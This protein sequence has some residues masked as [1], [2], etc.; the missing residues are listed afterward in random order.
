MNW[1][2]TLTAYPVVLFTFFI[3]FCAII[4]SF[5]NVIIYRYPIM[6]EREWENDCLEQL[7][8]PLKPKTDRFNICLPHSHCPTC[9]H[10]IPFW[11]N[12]PIISYLLLKG[13]CKFCSAPISFQYFLVEILSP[14]LGTIVVLQYGFTPTGM[15]LLLVTFGLLVLS[16]I[17]FNHH[18]LPDVIT[19]ILLWTGL[20]I[21]TQH[22]L[23][24]SSHAIFGAVTGYLFLWGIAK[25]Y[26]LFRKKEGMG[27]G[28]CKM[29]AMI[30]AFVGPLA[31]PNV[32]LLSTVLALFVSI[33]L[34]TIKKI[35]HSNPIPFGPYIA[36]AGWCVILFGNTITKWL[37]A[38]T[39]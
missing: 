4:G 11:L 2:L 14:L 20:I 31:L 1:L 30:G 39:S 3:V 21:S 8:Q 37:L 18:F 7:K 9:K 25:L 38:W 12:I 26:F 32:L 28:D 19:Y 6:L 10:A 5:L 13:K 15:A 33:F 29:L 24:T 36:V 16:F 22:L 35:K 27:L 17:D 23:I 34:L